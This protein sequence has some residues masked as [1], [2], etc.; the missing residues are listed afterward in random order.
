VVDLGIVLAVLVGERMVG[1]NTRRVIL[2][3]FLFF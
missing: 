2:I 1:K 3:L